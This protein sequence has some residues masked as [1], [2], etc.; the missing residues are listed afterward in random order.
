MASRYHSRINEMARNLVLL[1]ETERTEADTV[2]GLA[3][4]PNAHRIVR[5]WSEHYGYSIATVASVIA[6]VSPQCP[7]T[8]NLIIADDILA[9]NTPSIGALK[10]NVS[11]AEAIRNGRLSDTLTVFKSAPKVASFSRNLAGD[12]SLVTVDTHALQAA[13][14]D[15]EVVLGLKWNT[16]EAFASAYVHASK[17]VGIEPAMF[18]A[19]IWHTWKRMYPPAAKRAR[20]QQWSVMGEVD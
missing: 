3:W 11:K 10:V 7:W 14:C 15:V 1:W 4:Y 2:N 5:E 18:Q 9:C 12:Y 16:Y 17:V 6:A 8:R 13:L 19:V 20:R